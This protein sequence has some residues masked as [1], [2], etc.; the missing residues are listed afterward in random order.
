M[1]HPQNR[2][3]DRPSISFR[4]GLFFRHPLSNDLQWE[5]V[6]LFCFLVFF[7][8]LRY[9]G[10]GNPTQPSWTRLLTFFPLNL[11]AHVVPSTSVPSF[12]RLLT[13][14]PK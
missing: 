2:L 11:A 12:W 14:S 10:F 6:V 5:Y 7:F 9:V 1:P 13:P 8:G 3:T 4:G